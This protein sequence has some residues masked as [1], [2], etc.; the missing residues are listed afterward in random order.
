[1]QWSWVSEEQRAGAVEQFANNRAEFLLVST[2]IILCSKCEEV[3]DDDEIA[4]TGMTMANKASI[5]R[6]PN[7]WIADTG[8]TSNSTFD[9]SG[10]RVI[11]ETKISFEIS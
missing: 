8:A 4:V 3:T 5:L 11:E 10:M 1:M 7:M 6:D 2:N 9:D